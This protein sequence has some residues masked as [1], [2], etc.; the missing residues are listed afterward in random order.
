MNY[1]PKFDT[2]EHNT[3]ILGG[4]T[5][6]IDNAVLTIDGQP[7][8]TSTSSVDVEEWYFRSTTSN[9]N[10]LNRDFIR[11]LHT[12]PVIL[13]LPVS[14][15]DGDRVGVVDLSGNAEVN[16]ITISGNGKPIKL[17]GVTNNTLMLNT[18]Y[19]SVILQYSSNLNK[20]FV[21]MCNKVLTETWV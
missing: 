4:S 17:Y 18:N 2:T 11:L 20:W 6:S 3:I 8:S 7:I 9:Y 19:V 21:E 1:N 15:V 16:T 12:T 13:T 5:L 10:M 14:P